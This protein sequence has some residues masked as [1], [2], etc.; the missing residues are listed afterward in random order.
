MGTHYPSFLTLKEIINSNWLTEKKKEREK[1][2]EKRKRE[3][4][5][6]EGGREE[7][8]REEGKKYIRF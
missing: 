5:E 1:E 7:E 2:K 8:G 6:G 3:E 4:R